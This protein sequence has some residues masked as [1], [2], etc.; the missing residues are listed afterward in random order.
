MRLHTGGGPHTFAC[1]GPTT[2]T[3][4]AE[5]VIDNDVILDGTGNLTIDGNDDHRVLSVVPGATAE[6]I[7]LTVTGGAL[8]PDGG[9]GAGI[10]NE[11]MLTITNSSIASNGAA[12][13]V[14]G[15]RWRYLQQWGTDAGEQHRAG[16]RT[17]TTVADSTTSGQPH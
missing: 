14:S 4:Q 11:G 8:D 1:N 10:L 9:Q 6:L 16:K 3:T 2:V 5:I 12:G 7:A 15:S 13:Y 17:P